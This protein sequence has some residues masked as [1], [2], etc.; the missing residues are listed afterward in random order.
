MG[1]HLAHWDEEGT[2]IYIN[3]AAFVHYLREV[4]EEG[5]ISVLESAFDALECFLVDGDSDMHDFAGLGI[6]ETLQNVASHQPYGR[7]VFVLLKGAIVAP[8]EYD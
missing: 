1:Q 4:Y 8:V 3:L 7:R 5:R 2:G 6:I